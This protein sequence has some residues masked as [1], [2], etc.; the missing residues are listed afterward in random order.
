MASISR[1]WRLDSIHEER[2]RR[3][4][5]FEEDVILMRQCWFVANAMPLASDFFAGVCSLASY[6]ARGRA[7][8]CNPCPLAEMLHRPFCS[9]AIIRSISSISFPE[10]FVRN[11]SNAARSL[12]LSA[13]SAAFTAIPHFTHIS[14]R[15]AGV[16]VVHLGMNTDATRGLPAP[17]ISLKNGYTNHQQTYQI[18]PR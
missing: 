14:I 9:C 16:R 6:L 2:M 12:A 11:S 13:S 3:R 18:R 7:R 5:H 15:S 4:L 17:S 10:A 8:P 1:L